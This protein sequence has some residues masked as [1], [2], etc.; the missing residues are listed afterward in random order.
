MGHRLAYVPCPAAIDEVLVV[1][2][3]PLADIV[4]LYE[5]ATDVL[6]RSPTRF[7]FDAD[8]ARPGHPAAHFTINSAECGIACA[9]PIYVKRFVDFV[10][11]HFYPK[12]WDAHSP[13]FAE[14][15]HLHV[16]NPTLTDDDRAGVH[17]AWETRRGGHSPELS[18]STTKPPTLIPP[19]QPRLN[20]QIAAVAGSYSQ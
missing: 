3:H 14:A 17:L 6:L 11:R 15:A 10:Y 13:F 12:L 18:M 8:S 7:D 9:A 19:A 2:G 4:S 20:R 16:G 1:E 5:R